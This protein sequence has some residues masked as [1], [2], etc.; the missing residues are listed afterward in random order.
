ME[1]AFVY[2]VQ[3]G[4]CVCICACMAKPR[5][6][7]YASNDSRTIANDGGRGKKTIYSMNGKLNETM[8]Q[9]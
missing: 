2:E 7:S 8:M 4:V 9:Q 3:C 1:N 6:E 5:L